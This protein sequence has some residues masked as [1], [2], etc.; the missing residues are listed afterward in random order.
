MALRIKNQWFDN[1]RPKSAKETASV[2]AFIVWRVTQNMVK[3]MRE[4]RFDIDVGPQY[5][6]FMREILGFLIQVVDRMAFER[7]DAE[8]RA[9]FTGAL[10][11]R[12]AE[13][14]E[15]SEQEWMG[16]PPDGAD[17]WRN[18][19]IDFCNE[20]GEAYAEFDHGP[21]G[22]DFC[23]VRYLGSR[24]EAVVPA[25]LRR[26][27]VVSG[28]PLVA[29]KGR[30]FRIGEAVFEGTGD[31]DPCSRME[32]ALGPGGYNA[33]RQHGGLCARVIASGSFALGDAVEPLAP[34]DA[35]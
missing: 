34:E 18:Q 22:P 2:V 26:N 21:E 8:Q 25:T 20:L 17:S 13:I 28:L 32:A 9:E 33:M 31:C 10:V 11:R 35:A 30:R 5:F 7:M 27:L 29:L 24:V 19:F 4:A 6:A 12:V 1:G 23:F 16:S 3:Q 15:E 14:L